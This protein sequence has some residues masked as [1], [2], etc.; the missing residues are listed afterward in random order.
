MNRRISYR[1]KIF[2]ALLSRIFPFLAFDKFNS[3]RSFTRD[4]A[5]DLLPVASAAWLAVS[6]TDRRCISMQSVLIG[7]CAGCQQQT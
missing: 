7:Q 2:A 5:R 1:E 6:A 4:I 3:R